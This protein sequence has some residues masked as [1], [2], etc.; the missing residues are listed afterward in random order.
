M[1]SGFYMWTYNKLN[2]PEAGDYIYLGNLEYIYVCSS[3]EKIH[4]R[5]GS[6]ARIII[7][8]LKY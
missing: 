7:P 4:Y 8:E 5:Q 6:Y 2:S 3:N 1:L